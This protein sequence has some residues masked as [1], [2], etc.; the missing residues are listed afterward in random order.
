MVWTVWAITVIIIVKWFY[1]DLIVSSVLEKH[2]VAYDLLDC[3]TFELDVTWFVKLFGFDYVY[4]T[5]MEIEIE[6][7]CL[8]IWLLDFDPIWF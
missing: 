3:T 2:N 6:H 7:A 8:S 4:P 5:M 1:L